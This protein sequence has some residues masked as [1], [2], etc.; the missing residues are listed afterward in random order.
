MKTSFSKRWL[1]YLQTFTNE[2]KAKIFQSPAQGSTVIAECI[3]DAELKL[4]SLT[5]AYATEN[6]TIGKISW[7]TNLFSSSVPMAQFF[8]LIKKLTIMDNLEWKGN[9]NQVKGKIK[10]KHGDFTDDEL[11]YEEGKDDQFFGRLQTKLGKTK[12]EVIHWIRSF[13]NHND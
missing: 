1:V 11:E 4:R 6:N 2:L 7:L 8:C 12:D 13:G 5:S 10:E 9:W 3:A